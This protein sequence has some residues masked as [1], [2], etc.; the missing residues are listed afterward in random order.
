[1]SPTTPS[2]HPH[3]YP[4]AGTPPPPPPPPPQHTSHPHPHPHVPPDTHQFYSYPC[5]YNNILLNI[6]H[7]SIE[8]LQLES[9]HTTKMSWFGGCSVGLNHCRHIIH[10][11]SRSV[12]KHFR[13]IIEIPFW[14]KE[15]RP[16]THSIPAHHQ[17]GRSMDKNDWFFL[18]V[19]DLQIRRANPWID[20][21][22]CEPDVHSSTADVLLSNRIQCVCV[23]VCKKQ[24]FD[25]GV[26]LLKSYPMPIYS[27][28][29][30]W[31]FLKRDNSISNTTG[32]EYDCE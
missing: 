22:W 5:L 7:K 17:R 32:R 15:W 18:R 9:K 28:D 11:H 26:K 3:P 16:H 1:M 23:C 25:I 29:S 21:Y 13:L 2:P 8:N 4:S 20:C 27:P 14:P 30:C 10:V 19:V 12:Q 24:I 6:S 31:I